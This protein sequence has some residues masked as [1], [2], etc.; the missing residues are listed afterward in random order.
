MDRKSKL[1]RWH[2]LTRCFA[3]GILILAFYSCQQKNNDQQQKTYNA[4]SITLYRNSSPVWGDYSSGPIVKDGNEYTYTNDKG[5]TSHLI[6]REGETVMIVEGEK[7]PT[8]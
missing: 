5:L 1:L 4:G 6:T 7:R 2:R 3:A 8:P